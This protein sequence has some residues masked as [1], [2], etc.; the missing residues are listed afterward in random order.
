[1][2]MLMPRPKYTDGTRRVK[3]ST[4]KPPSTQTSPHHRLVTS[5]NKI[6]SDSASQVALSTTKKTVAAFALLA[7]KVAC[8]AA[9]FCVS[10]WVWIKIHIGGGVGGPGISVTVSKLASPVIGP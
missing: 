5:I 4:C 8:P 9:S 7:H 6:K 10:Q 1:M 2:P 3:K